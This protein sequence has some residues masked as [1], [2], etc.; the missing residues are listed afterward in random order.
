MSHYPD[1]VNQAFTAIGV[2]LG[3]PIIYITR[4]EGLRDFFEKAQ[5]S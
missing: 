5:D 1:Q 3:L 2:T 4:V